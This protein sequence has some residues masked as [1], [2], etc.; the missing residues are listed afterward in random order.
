MVNDGL[1]RS[2]Q[3][4]PRF[5]PRYALGW[6][7]FLLIILEIV[8]RVAFSHPGLAV[9]NEGIGTQTMD[10]LLEQMQKSPAVNKVPFLGASVMQ[11]LKNV[12]PELT[13]P[14]LAT[15]ILKDKGLNIFG[16]NLAS[17]GLRMGDTY[18]L[19]RESIRRGAT[20][21]PI[22]LHLK[23]FSG[24]FMKQPVLYDGNAYYLIGH[25]QIVKIRK[26]EL[27]IDDTRWTNIVADRSLA[28]AWAFYRYSG[29]LFHL[30]VDTDKPPME[31]VRR[32]IKLRYGFAR[33]LSIKAA[34][35]DYDDRNVD[36]VWKNTHPVYA[37][38]NRASYKTSDISEK[39]PLWPL[40]DRMCKEA[41]EAGVVLLFFFSPLNKPAIEQFHQFPWHIHKSFVRAATRHIKRNGQSVVNLTH[42][43]PSKYFTDFDHLNMNG[44][45]AMAKAIAPHIKRAIRKSKRKNQ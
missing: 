45:Q 43:V 19:M 22:A 2:T 17:A 21:I 8:F 31:H 14:V 38:L 25:P 36:N 35:M 3:D 26:Q 16:T 13:Y 39:N 18:L 12:P 27:K 10:Y 9:R 44:H 37:Q 32:W 11:G 4:R 20:V 23:T 40:I 42:A 33:K 1:P 7:L 41:N 5:R 24:S 28:K 34:A 30:Y 15:D 29:M 6:A